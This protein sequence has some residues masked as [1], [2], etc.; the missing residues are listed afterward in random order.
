MASARPVI[1]QSYSISFGK[2]GDAVSPPAYNVL[3]N[4]RT[5]S[6]T[7]RAELADQLAALASEEFERQRKQVAELPEGSQ[8]LLLIEGCRVLDFQH[9]VHFMSSTPERFLTEFE[10]VVMVRGWNAFVALLLPHVGKLKG[11]PSAEST[12]EFR[13]VILSILLGLG[14]A[15]ML[16]ENAEMFRH[17]MAECNIENNVITF[18]MSDR[19]GLDHFLD[20]LEGEKLRRLEEE[21]PGRDIFRKAIAETTVPDLDERIRALVFPWKVS[22]KV[23]MT[24]YG[25]EPDIDQHYFALV[26]ETTHESIDDAGIHDDTVLGS[27]TGK[28][29]RRVVFAITSF[30]LKHMRFVDAAKSAH[31]EINYAMSLTIWKL[32]SDLVDSIALLPGMTE[33]IASAAID[34]LTVESGDEAYFRNEITP[35]IPMLI[36][37]AD[38]YLLSPVSSIFRNPF[39]GIR[40]LHEARDSK[41]ATRLLSHRERWMIDDL[42][43]LFRGGRYVCMEGPTKLRRGGSVITDIDAAVLDT[44]TGEL[45]LFQLKW[46]DFNSNDVAKQ[47]SRARNF[48]EKVDAW[49]QAVDGWIAEFG[50]ALLVNNLRMRFPDDVSQVRLFAVGRSAARFQSYGYVSQVPAV[51]SVTWRQFARLRYEIGPSA[52]VLCDLHAAIQGERSTP[53]ILR[54]IRQQLVLRD[55]T[56]VFENLWNAYDDEDATP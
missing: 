8:T 4:H 41:A 52:N 36:E 12:P 6:M 3:P 35:F 34:L 26:A 47:R 13:Q 29:L 1:A 53:V 18:R 55:H 42:Y 48:V 5:R 39:H 21:M 14:S 56:V 54:P 27:I 2:T 50:T 16:R 49:A 28:D 46:Q 17:G 7:T 23:T 15:T 37:V 19:C 38:N 44:I 10:F 9:V 45:G 25:A 22:E 33:S 51:A 11:I 40:M 32:R 31:P 20:R 43:N 30:Y 24:G